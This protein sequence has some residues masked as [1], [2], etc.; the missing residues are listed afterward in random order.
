MSCAATAAASSRSGTWWRKRPGPSAPQ[1]LVSRDRHFAD[2][3][4]AGADSAADI[5]IIAERNDVAIHLFQIAGNRD[6]VHREGNGPVLHP[7][8][9]RSARVVTCY[10]VDALAHH[11]GD[12]QT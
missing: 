1:S 3:H 6:L 2:E 9:T 11:L 12:Q 10:P 7:E 4:R 5:N 8:P